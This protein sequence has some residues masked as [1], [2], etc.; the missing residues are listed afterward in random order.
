MATGKSADTGE[1][2]GM[3]PESKHY[4]AESWQCSS[5]E[6]TSKSSTL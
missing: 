1:A 6:V 5:R 4:I 2:D 3:N